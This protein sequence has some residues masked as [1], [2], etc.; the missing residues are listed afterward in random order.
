MS[1]EILSKLLLEYDQKKRKAELDLDDRKNELYSKFPRLQEIE[2][3]LNLFA[4]N[5]AKNILR[6]DTT[7][8]NDLNLKVA[9]VST[10]LAELNVNIED[11][12]QTLMQGHFVMFMLCDITN[13]QNSF[14]EI[15]DKLQ[16]EGENFGVEIWVQ[17]KEIFD[18]MHGIG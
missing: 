5:T 6:G 17:R 13:S 10:I 8:L 11:I 15:K 2:S 18:T 3:E 12:K 1:N 16:Q 9:K 4:I 14:K 7:S